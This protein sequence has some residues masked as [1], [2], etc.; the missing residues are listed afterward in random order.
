[1]SQITRALATALFALFALGVFVAT[2][3]WKT[4]A[5]ASFGLLQALGLAASQ[6]P[7]ADGPPDAPSAPKPLSASGTSPLQR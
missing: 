4:P 1:M 3:P 5:E 2:G 6:P 7:A